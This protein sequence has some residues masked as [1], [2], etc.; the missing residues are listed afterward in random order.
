MHMFIILTAVMVTQC[1]GTGQ[2]I[3][4]YAL[5]HSELFL[6]KAIPK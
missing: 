2:F 6:N 4:L 1:I 5:L 3:K